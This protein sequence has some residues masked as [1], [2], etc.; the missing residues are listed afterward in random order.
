[1]STND[2]LVRSVSTFRRNHLVL[3]TSEGYMIACDGKE[4]KP[5]DI[6]L[7]LGRYINCIGCREYM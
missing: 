4:V 5:E 1:M 2:E 3:L 6:K 7:I